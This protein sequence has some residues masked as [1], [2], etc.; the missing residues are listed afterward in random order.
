MIIKFKISNLFKSI[1]NGSICNDQWSV[2]LELL[3]S[4]VRWELGQIKHD[5]HATR[6]VAMPLNLLDKC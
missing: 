5:K 3:V 4:Y 6:V 2:G 1:P